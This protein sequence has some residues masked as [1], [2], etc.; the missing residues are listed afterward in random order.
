MMKI[1]WVFFDIDDTLFNSSELALRARKNAIRA[2]IRA[3]LDADEDEAYARLMRIIKKRG[4]NY[5]HHYDELM[6]HYG[7]RNDRYIAAG[8]VAYHDTKRAYLNAFPEVLPTLLELNRKHKLGIISNGKGVKQWEKLI[9]M[10]LQHFFDEVFI[11]GVMGVEK[12]D[13]VMFEKALKEAGCKAEEAVMVGDKDSDILPA[14]KLG[15]KT[16]CLEKDV[17]ADYHINSFKDILGVV[18]GLKSK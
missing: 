6:E 13:T 14:K 10:G 12:P 9:R 1:K 2:M 7:E 17:N 5:D 16:I 18:D 4:T 15:M 11:S 8:V 3:G